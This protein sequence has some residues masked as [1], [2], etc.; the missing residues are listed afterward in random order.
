ME[1]QVLSRPQNKTFLRGITFLREATCRHTLRDDL[2]AGAV[3]AGDPRGGVGENFCKKCI[4]DQVLARPQLENP[5]LHV[6]GIL[7]YVEG[8]N[9]PFLN[10]AGRK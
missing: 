6:S 9:R 3:R 5:T 2:K 4:R 10:C 1:V 8:R 7:I